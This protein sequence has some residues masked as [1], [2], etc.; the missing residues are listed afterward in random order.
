MKR[1]PLII[2][3]A[4]FSL[5]GAVNYGFE[6]NQ[7]IS[8]VELLPDGKAIIRYAITFTCRHGYDPI[9]IVDIGLPVK[10]YDLNSAKAS[11]ISGNIIPRE[12]NQAALTEGFTERQIIAGKQTITPVRLGSIEKSEYAPLGIGV[13]VP[14]GSH[15]ISSGEQST[16]LFQITMNNYIYE[17]DQKGQASLRFKPTWFGSEFTSGTTFYQIHYIFP[18]GVTDKESVYH[19]SVP[20]MMEVIMVGTP[21]ARVHYMYEVQGRPDESPMETGISFPAQYVAK[22][23]KK[24][25]FIQKL[26]GWLVENIVCICPVIFFIG[27]ILLSSIGSRNRKMKYMPPAASVEGVGIKRGLTAVEAAI[28]IEMPLD[29]VATMILFGLLKKG[30]L[31]VTSTQKPIKLEKQPMPE[32][33]TLHDYETAFISAISGD[34]KLVTKSMRELMVNL[35]KSVNTK[36][37]GFSRRETKEYYRTIVSQA[38]EQVKSGQTPDAMMNAWEENVEWTMLDRDYEHRYREIFSPYSVYY[39]VWLPGSHGSPPIG[40]GVGIPGGTGSGTPISVPGSDFAHDVATQMEGMAGGLVGD[41]GDFTSSVTGVTNPPP[42]YTSSSG[43]GGG[44][45][46][47]GCACA[48]ACAGCACACAGGGR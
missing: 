14:L 44:S 46:S 43:G 34:G 19:Q 36:L 4:V 32:G 41:T 26:F 2:L 39:P 16:L 24:P 12:N 6:V 27:I 17:G 29:R 5:A 47:G 42:V 3:L 48:C 21:Q 28:L 45:S 31:K 13:Q 33:L 10:S 35:I 11:I 25:G 22:L 38:W 9:D 40:G 37:K 8:T 23:V 7:S 18:P 20:Q 15:S 1:L 30:V